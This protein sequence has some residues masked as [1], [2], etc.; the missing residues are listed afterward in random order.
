[1]N[2]KLYRLKPITFVPQAGYGYSEDERS[3]A[4]TP[5]GEM[6][7][8]NDVSDRLFG[9][10]KVWFFEDANGYVSFTE[11]TTREAAERA[12]VE[13]YVARATECMDEVTP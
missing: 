8:F 9:G 13:W 6:T 11:H 5:Y 4:K 1:M 10:V 7:V 3:V 12:A 2:D